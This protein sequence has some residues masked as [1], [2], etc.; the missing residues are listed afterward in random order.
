MLTLTIQV[1]NRIRNFNTRER[2]KCAKQQL[3]MH[4]DQKPMEN[5]LA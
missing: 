2:E 4:K 3:V 1:Q 5:L